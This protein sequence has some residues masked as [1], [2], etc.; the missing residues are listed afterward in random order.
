MREPNWFLCLYS[1]QDDFCPTIRSCR[2][3]RELQVKSNNLHKLLLTTTVLKRAHALC[4]VIIAEQERYKAESIIVSDVTGGDGSST[5][6]KNCREKSAS[7]I[8]NVGAIS[9]V[10]T[11]TAGKGTHT[12]TASPCTDTSGNNPISTEMLSKH[13]ADGAGTTDSLP[14]AVVKPAV[15]STPKKAGKVK[16]AFRS[17]TNGLMKKRRSIDDTNQTKMLVQV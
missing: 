11:S 1:N 6:E 4:H 16:S 7:R 8:D 17:L 5:I 2:S 12:S 10:H 9:A 15:V 3:M 14:H 13:G